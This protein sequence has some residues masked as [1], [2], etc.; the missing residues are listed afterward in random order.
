M[1][2][3]KKRNSS[4]SPAN[5]GFV[6]VSW[7]DP[8]CR[9]DFDRL[10]GTSLSHGNSLQLFVWG[11]SESTFPPGAAVMLC[12]AARMH[13]SRLEA[14]ALERLLSDMDFRGLVEILPPFAAAQIRDP[15]ELVV[16]I[17]AL[18]FR[19]LYL[20]RGIGWAAISTSAHVLG[21]WLHAE[22]DHQAV[23]VQSLLGWQLGVR[24]L[25]DQIQ[26]IGAGTLMTLRDGVAW[27]SSEAAHELRRYDLDEAVES[28]GAILRS[29]MSKYLDD[30]PD[31]LMQLT[32]GQ[33]SRILLAAIPR[34]RRR[35]LRVVTLGVAGTEDVVIAADLASR[36]EMR[37]EVVSLAGLADLSPHDAFRMCVYASA[38]VEHMA[39]PLAFASVTFAESQMDQGPRISGLGG[40]VARGFYYFGPNLRLPVT[41]GLVAMLAGWRMFANEAVSSN[42]LDDRFARYARSHTIDEITRILSATGRAWSEATDEFYLWQRMQRWSGIVHTAVCNE[43]EIVNPMLDDRFISIARGLQPSSKRNSLFLSRLLIEL[44]RELAQIPL[45]GRPAPVAFAYR[46]FNSSVRMGSATAMKIASKARQRLSGGHKAPAGGN[47]LAE[48]L[49]QYLRS[50]PSQLDPVRHLGIFKEEWLNALSSGAAYPDSAALALLINLIAAKSDIAVG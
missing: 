11:Y 41:R 13:D 27:T 25:Y 4:Q 39:D 6:A 3:Q 34:A 2:E 32:G 26:K 48:K 50:D 36:Y 22:L 35:G 49:I 43:R 15:N 1:A 37:H 9:P 18:G 20:Y 47:I 31:P 46:N 17:D 28:A 29:Y 19:H 45:D 38:R 8:S 16:S 21:D 42:V 23:A 40:E 12:K 5:P 44:D 30:Y 10:P 24:T 33:D 14:G 7:S